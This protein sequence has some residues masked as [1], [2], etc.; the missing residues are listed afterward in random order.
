MRRPHPTRSSARI[1]ASALV[2]LA[3]TGCGQESADP[4]EPETSSSPDPTTTTSQE[5]SPSTSAKPRAKREQ[6]PDEVRVEVTVQGDVVSPNAEVLEVEVGEPITLAIT[7][8]R[9]GELHIHSSPEQYVEFPAGRTTESF[10][11]ER[12]GSV[13]VEEHESGAQ[14]L[15][16]LAQ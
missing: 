12:P 8:D 15:R 5:P 16:V 2:L 1:A 7:S 9:P 13:E 4:A 3:L 14:I 10:A 11:V 6:S